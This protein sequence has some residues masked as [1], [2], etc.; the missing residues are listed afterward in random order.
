MTIRNA[1]PKTWV[2]QPSYDGLWSAWPAG[3]KPEPVGVATTFDALYTPGWAPNST[4]DLKIKPTVTKP[5]KTTNILT[6]GYRDSQF[7]TEI[8]RLTDLTEIPGGSPI[9]IRH[10]YARRQVWNADS[11][12]YIAITS[13][14]WWYL[15]DADTT[16]R[17]NGGRTQ[18]GAGN[19]A[20]SFLAGQCEPIWHPTDPNKLWY[21]EGLTWYE[22]TFTTWGQAPTRT[23]LFDLTAKLAAL[24]S[25]WNTAEAAWFQFEGRPSYDGRWWGLA[26]E[27]NLAG[28]P[29]NIGLIMFDRQT[30]TITGAVLTGGNRPNWNSTSPLGNYVMASWYG[31]AASSLA[32]EQARGV[33]NAQGVWLFNRDGSVARV[34]SVLGEHSDMLLDKDGNEVYCSISYRG[35]ADE[36]PNDGI[37]FRRLNDGVAWMSPIMVGL[38]E[39]NPTGAYAQGGFHASGCAS[40]RPGWAVISTY[41]RA[42]SV[43]VYSGMVFV[44]EATPTSPRFYRLAHTH[45][46]DENKDTGN[47]YFNEAHGT[48]NNDLTRIAFASDF[49]NNAVPYESYQI[50]LPS[51]AIPS[52]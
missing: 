22:L 40:A 15:Y 52:D 10:E 36:L 19:Q 7:D 35:F 39:S 42:N 45:C 49:G 41:Y 47:A 26:I 3:D 50:C 6:G 33:T 23:V 8:R 29:V 11:T 46:V 30:D 38:G 20:V 13:Q 28:P 32:E 24:G 48:P 4:T 17:L 9:Y 12:K 43:G 16:Q 21:Y 25:P 44:V 14:S 34:L 18:A 51:W 1:N 31:T 5:A 27:R 37:Y 2:I